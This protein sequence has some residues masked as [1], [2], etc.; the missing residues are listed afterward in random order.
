MRPVSIVHER[1]R[2]TP[3][4]EPFW[5]AA[6]GGELRLPSCPA[7]EAWLWF[8][9]ATCPTCGGDVEWRAAS[10]LA[11]LTSF[12]VERRATDPRWRD[13]VPYVIGYVTL[14]EGVVL[15]SDIVGAEPGELGIGTRLRVRFEPTDDPAIAVPVFEPFD[16]GSPHA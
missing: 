13:R 5:T 15:L 12:T 16:E 1:P 3:E 14:D 7:C 9:R 11:T 10:G 6:A 8:P 4:A 2:V